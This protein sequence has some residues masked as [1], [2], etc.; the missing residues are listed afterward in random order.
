[1]SLS[2]AIDFLRRW[3]LLL[4][5]GAIV[6]GVAGDAVVRRTP[7]A[8]QA[9]VTLQ[10]ASGEPAVPGGEARPTDQLGRTYAEL[11]KTS[12]VIE[13]AAP[14]VGLQDVPTRDLRGRITA[15]PV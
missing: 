8:Y 10:V 1:M 3:L 4:V 11:V 13:A 12:P 2:D 6:G 7:P 9:Q 15:T 14:R 5:L